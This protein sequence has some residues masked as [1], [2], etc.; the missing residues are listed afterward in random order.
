MQEHVGRALP[1]PLCWELRAE[2]L[3]GALVLRQVTEMLDQCCLCK[4]RIKIF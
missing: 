3:Q 1:V 2:G 4:K